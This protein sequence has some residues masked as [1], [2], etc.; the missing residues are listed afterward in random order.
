MCLTCLFLNRSFTFE[1]IGIP[2]LLPLIDYI[3]CILWLGWKRSGEVNDMKMMQ[4]EVDSYCRGI[5]LVC[6][7]ITFFLWGF[8]DP[9]W[10]AEICAYFTLLPQKKLCFQY[11][12][13]FLYS[14]YASAHYSNIISLTQKLGIS[15]IY[16]N[17][18][19]FVRKCKAVKLAL[20]LVYFFTRFPC[21]LFNP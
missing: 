5:K 21:S 6:T 11:F 14:T 13:V 19:C 8:W 9:P 7:I 12:C 18:R 10:K 20:S 15:N 3:V 1:Y 2:L 16:S 4:T 17:V